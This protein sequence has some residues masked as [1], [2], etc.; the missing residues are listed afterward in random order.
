M[1]VLFQWQCNEK[2]VKKKVVG[3]KRYV[4]LNRYIAFFNYENV[5]LNSI[6]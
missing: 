4:V 1:S 2:M 5:V 6:Y 3:K